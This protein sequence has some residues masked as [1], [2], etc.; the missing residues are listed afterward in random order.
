MDRV[1][2]VSRGDEK[3]SAYLESGMKVLIAFFHGVGDC[4]MFRV[5]FEQL[6]KT[7][8]NI[9]FDIG[10]CA[11]L[12]QEFIFPEAVMLAPDWRE[13]FDTLGYD[14]VFSCN[15]PMNEHQTDLTKSEWC[16]VHELGI[17]PEWGHGI[18]QP[19]NNKLIGVHFNITCLPGCCNAEH[20]TAKAIWD[21]I[22]SIGA[23]PIETHFQHIFHNPVNA[24][25]DFVDCGVRRVTPKLST[26]AGLLKQ[27]Y[28]FI[29][30]VSGNFHMAM[31]IMPPERVCLLERDFKAQSFTK[32][33]IKTIDINNYKNGD[34]FGWLSSIGLSKD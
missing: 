19:G 32:I 22:L 25:Y 5:V 21:E 9:H 2:D 6:K 26:L 28:A 16:C 15:F 10:L 1:I 13:K 30:V 33:G 11:G 7:Y 29:G 3:L 24:K 23:I 17:E 27:C 31:S 20:D 14:L 12:D 4:V 34:V 8:P 18:M